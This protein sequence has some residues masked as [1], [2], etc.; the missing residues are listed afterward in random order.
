MN[1][2]EQARHY[3]S[4]VAQ[5]SEYLLGRGITGAMAGAALLGFAADPLTGHDQMRGRLVIPYLTPTGVADLRFRAV[6]ADTQPKYLSLPGHKP[7][8]YNTVVLAPD[9]ELV[10][11]TEGELDALILTHAVGIPAVAVPGAQAWNPRRHSRVFRG[12]RTVLV[13]ADGDQPGRELGNQIARDVPQAA[14]VGLGD[15]CDVT[16]YYLAHGRE[17]LRRRAGLPDA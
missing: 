12:Y 10:A 8:L 6:D 16:D 3:H 1:L 7:R 11:V 14:V 15:G 17:A 5:A 2:T 9:P 4:S 13:F